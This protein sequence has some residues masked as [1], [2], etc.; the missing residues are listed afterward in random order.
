[1]NHLQITKDSASS[2]IISDMNE[3]YIQRVQFIIIIIITIQYTKFYYYYFR[4][5]YAQ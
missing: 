1:M 2:H 4:F 3:T 5:Y